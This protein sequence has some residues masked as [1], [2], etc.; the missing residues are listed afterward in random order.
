MKLFVSSEGCRIFD[1]SPAPL[2]QILAEQGINPLEVLVSR[3]GKL[4][5]EDTIVGADDEIRVTRIAHGG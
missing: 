5:P 3:N 2:E 1:H 4:I